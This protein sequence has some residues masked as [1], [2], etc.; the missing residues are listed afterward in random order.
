[1]IREEDYYSNPRLEMAPKDY[2]PMYEDYDGGDF[3]PEPEPNPY[4]G[5]YDDGGDDD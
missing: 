3:D 5:D 2:A 1:M 4:H